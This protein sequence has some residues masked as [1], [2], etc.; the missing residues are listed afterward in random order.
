MFRDALELAELLF[1]IRILKAALPFIAGAIV[2][3]FPVWFLKDVG[4]I[5]MFAFIALVPLAVIW[6][7]VVVCSAARRYYR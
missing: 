4:V 3:I 7:L 5:L 1:A 2:L 6:A